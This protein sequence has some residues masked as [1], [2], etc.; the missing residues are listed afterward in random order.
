MEKS[1]LNSSTEIYAALRPDELAHLEEVQAR[2]EYL[3]ADLELNVSQKEERGEQINNLNYDKKFEM[4]TAEKEKK[5]SEMP[6][7]LARVEHYKS[8]QG[9][10][11]LEISDGEAE[12]WEIK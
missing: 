4:L 11:R 3:E 5:K 2:I 7:E 12:K 1:D 6:Y 9:I 10:R 8:T